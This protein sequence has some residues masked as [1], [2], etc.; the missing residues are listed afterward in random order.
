MK[1]NSLAVLVWL[2]FFGLLAR[3]ARAQGIGGPT[4]GLVCYYRLDG[5]AN[6][7]LGRGNA[8][9]LYN[10]AYFTNGNFGKPRAAVYCNGTG[11]YV[12][13]G[14]NDTVYPNQILTWSLWVCPEED[15]VGPVFWDDDGQNG[16]DRGI[17]IVPTLLFGGGLFINARPAEAPITG[18]GQLTPR[19]WHHLAYTADASGQSLYVDGALVAARSRPLA[20]HAGRSSVSLGAGNSSFTG[21]NSVYAVGFKGAI[22]QARIYQRALSAVEVAQVYNAE[23]GRGAIG[24]GGI[25]VVHRAVSLSFSNLVVR[26]AYQVQ[27]ASTAQGPFSNF[28]RPFL[29]TNSVMSIPGSVSVSGS[30]KL[31]FRVGAP[32]E[33]GP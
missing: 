7:I 1:P 33:D 29:A 32:R 22:C 6:D 10:G 18:A 24:N 2:S 20:D 15:A 4:N 14:K 19:V 21:P 26:S 11:G 5:N 27:A 28:S 13:M 23:S 9:V 8:G 31:F 16:G 25:V 3:E 17:S 12:Y 30:E